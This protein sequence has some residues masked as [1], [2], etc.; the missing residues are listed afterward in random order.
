[1]F[2]EIFLLILAGAIA[3]L[4]SW[5]FR[6][7]PREGW[8]ILACLPGRKGSDG[9]WKGINL[10]YYGFFNACAYVFAVVIFLLMMGALGVPVAGALSVVAPV[11]AIGMWA[12]RFIARWVEKKA[13]TFSVGAASF[14]C[15]L[16]TPLVI[17]AVNMTLGRWW[18]FHIPVVETMT[19][20]LVAYAFGEGIGRLACISF[21]CCY[22]KPL[23]DCGPRVQK[24]FH[25]W[26]FVF[27]GSTKKIA[28]AAQLEGQAVIP[29]QALTAVLYA[30]TGL[31]GLYLFLKGLIPAA[32]IL[33]LV[34]TQSWRFASEFLRAD[35]RGQKR[36]SA[37]QIMTLA[38][39]AYTFILLS[40]LTEPDP[41]LPHLASGLQVLWNPGLAACLVV[42]WVVAFIYTGKSEVT[43]S[44]IDI[45][46]VRKNI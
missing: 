20:M 12:A 28:Y 32:L 43:C 45:Q 31:A 30:G 33:T 16:V 19:A 46:V 34:V 1:M 22:G 11:L 14:A 36:I 26:H 35:H 25:R 18:L 42:L 15:V 2:D 40:F 27:W 37:Y 3:F 38:A 5:A 17:G 44:A 10:T 8:Q 4:F 7:L 21:G 9:V 41:V 13:H 29:I 39:M 6:T 23:A 24:I